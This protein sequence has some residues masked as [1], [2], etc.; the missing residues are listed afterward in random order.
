MG[1]QTARCLEEQGTGGTQAGEPRKDGK[2]KPKE[3]QEEIMSKE[4]NVKLELWKRAHELEAKAMEAGDLQAMGEAS[5]WK[6]KLALVLFAE[7]KKNTPQ[8]G[9]VSGNGVSGSLAGV[10]PTLAS[11]GVTGNEQ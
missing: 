6:G 7:E 10:A 3:E 2:G 8:E 9:F 5:E 1:E 11:V 4:I